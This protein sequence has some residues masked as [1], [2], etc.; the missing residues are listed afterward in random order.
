MSNSV[1]RRNLLKVA[2]LGLGALGTA[3]AASQ[4]AEARRLNLR[5]DVSGNGTT[6]GS[7]G[8]TDPATGF[9]INGN[10]FVIEGFIY[11]FGTLTTTNGISNGVL[12]TG[13]PEFPELV[14]A[15]WFCAGWFVRQGVFTPLGPQAFTNQIF[16]LVP[17]T[18]GT[19]TIITTGYEQAGPSGIRAVTGGTGRYARATGQVT[20]FGL[21]A[22]ITGGFGLR[23]VF[24]IVILP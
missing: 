11:P 14:I 5:V 19:D 18:P 2:S 16:D 12:P 9:P 20:Q 3:A 1:Q 13:E 10:N 15:T 6:I 17:S 24:E 8:P 23:Q 4:P 21:G 22:N 7:S